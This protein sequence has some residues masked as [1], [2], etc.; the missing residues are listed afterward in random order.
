[1]A[2]NQVQYY[3]NL[4][5]IYNRNPNCCKQ[6]LTQLSYK[7]R[8]N[9]FCSSSCAASFN[10]K[11]KPKRIKKNIKVNTG[12]CLFCKIQLNKN[13]KYCNAQCQQDFIWSQRKEKILKDGYDDNSR[14]H[15]LAK[16]LLLE[17][18]NNKCNICGL[19]EWLG[20]K[21]PLVLDHI[22][23][24]SNDGYLS[25]LRVICNN[26][27]ALTPTYK[28]KN[29]GNGRHYRRTRYNLGKSY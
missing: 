21:I 19:S 9:K 5:I 28:S 10:N 4:I 17:Q 18:S 1:M 16:K 14:N 12:F 3:Q 13:K 7:K 24:N 29:K 11:V 23:G 6:C 26:C 27:D 2:K 15:H 25:N 8:I 20:Q 22:N